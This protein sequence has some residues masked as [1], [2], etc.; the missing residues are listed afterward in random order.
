[1]QRLVV[2]RTVPA[3]CRARCPPRR[4]LNGSIRPEREARSAP[5][6]AVSAV[7]RGA[8]KETRGREFREKVTAH[9]AVEKKKYREKQKKRRNRE[10]G[11]MAGWNARR[12]D[13]MARKTKMTAYEY[14][15]S[16]L[17]RSSLKR[18]S[19]GNPRRRAHFC[20][21]TL[22]LAHFV[23]NK[24]AEERV[25][26]VLRPLSNARKLWEPFRESPLICHVPHYAAG[27]RDRRPTESTPS[28]L[29]RYLNFKSVAM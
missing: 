17:L 1:M 2:P 29:D 18:S 16:V 6:A 11:K 23:P 3:Q 10:G 19:F 14:V 21:E 12:A 28:S 4:N 7:P 25:I 9:F 5:V 27:P 13:I 20:P 22:C 15:F 26:A 24:P 8:H